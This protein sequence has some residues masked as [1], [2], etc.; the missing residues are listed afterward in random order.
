[1]N[2]SDGDRIPYLSYSGYD[3]VKGASVA[4]PHIS[5][6]ATMVL[7]S[8]QSRPCWPPRVAFL[9]LVTHETSLIG[10]SILSCWSI[11]QRKPCQR[12]NPL[13]CW[14][15][16]TDEKPRSKKPRRASV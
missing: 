11:G 7:C 3:P 13:F 16:G 10:C 15:S 6:P 2:I 4:A 5:K 8:L 14:G 1:M 9:K 12:G